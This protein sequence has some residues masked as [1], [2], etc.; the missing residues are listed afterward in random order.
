MFS[1]QFLL[2]VEDRTID[3]LQSKYKELKKNAR[4]VLAKAKR[5]VAQTGNQNLRSSTIK[6]LNDDTMLLL[7]KQLG[8]TASGF[9]S[10]HCK[11]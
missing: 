8:P 2:Q 11:R 10:K 5:E 1:I 4:H 6:S 3:K 9:Q 7:R